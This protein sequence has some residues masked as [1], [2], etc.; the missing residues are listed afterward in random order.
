MNTLENKKLAWLGTN[1]FMVLSMVI[2][3]GITRLTDSGLSMTTWNLIKGVIPPLNQ[4]E[5]INVFNLYKN[6]PEYNLKNFS[7]TLEEFKKIFFWEY[8]HRI[9]GRLIG[10]TFF[11]P[12]FYFWL[13]GYFNKNE[14]KLILLITLLGFFQAFMGWYMVESGLIDQPDVSH[15]RL[16]VHLITAFIIYSL[17][18]YYFWNIHLGKR[19]AVNDV[20][21]HKTNLHKKNFF[22]SL[23][24]LL[25]TVLAGA[26][27]SGT[28][29][30]LSYNNFPYMG[31]GFFATDFNIWGN[32]QSKK[33][34]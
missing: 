16:S 23:L 19:K 3:G 12:L 9:W 22:I 17:L 2:I 27:V 14:K 34:F 15:F 26:L 20:S 32:K 18:L 30:G 13:K 31:D 8:I 24:L 4:E 25:T 6:Y 1:L 33:S 10:F 28:E 29:A 11:I 5:W 21:A 7:M